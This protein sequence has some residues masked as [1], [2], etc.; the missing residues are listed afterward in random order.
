MAL[1]VG[2]IVPKGS[3]TII[4]PKGPQVI[5]T[6]E[7]FSDKR[8]KAAQ[9]QERKQFAE[10]TFHPK[11][12]DAPAYIKRIAKSMALARKARPS[13]KKSRKPDWK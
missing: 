3:L 12:N 4:G 13:K 9:E 7:I 11:T 8:R 2:Q 1:E 10:C 6:E 5:S